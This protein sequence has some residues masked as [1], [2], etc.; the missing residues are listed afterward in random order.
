MS[1]DDT[2]AN[3]DAA[4]QNEGASDDL[5]TNT[6]TDTGSD[7]SQDTGTDGGGGDDNAGDEGGFKTKF[8]DQQKRANNAEN[9]LRKAGLDP[10]T[11]KPKES[12]APNKDGKAL[13]DEDTARIVRSEERSERAAL[14]S[15]GITHPDDIEY[16]RKQAKHF[17][18][19]VEQAAVD[20]F[21]KNKLDR[22]KATRD[23]KDAT[24]PP[25]K[26]GG[27][28]SNKKFPDFSKM[29]NTEFDAWEKANRS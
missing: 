17:D 16:V 3:S 21:V 22:M 28:A 12:R 6:D 9:L 13:S 18:G 7:D 27:S 29:S 4:D 8:E 5:D 20:E 23:T 11:G 26:R 19:D 2:Q 24:P 14:R 10:K 1:Q 25:N 15:M